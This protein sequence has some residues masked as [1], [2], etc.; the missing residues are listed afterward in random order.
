MQKITDF[1][2]GFCEK[3]CVKTASRCYAP[4]ECEFGWICRLSAVI[5]EK[6]AWGIHMAKQNKK[7]EILE[8]A[9]RIFSRKGSAAKIG[10]IGVEA[11]V[12]DSVI[13][14][15][16]KNK[17]DLM[18]SVLSERLKW[19][20]KRVDEHLKGIIDPASKLSKLIWLQL[21]YHDRHPDY[22]ALQ[23]FECRSNRKF[24]EHEAHRLTMEWAGYFNAPLAEGVSTGQFDPDLDIQVA[25][26]AVLGMLDMENI[27]CLAAGE[28]ENNLSDQEA[29]MDLI[30]A[31]LRAPKK[32][33]QQSCTKSE[34]II[35]AAEKEISQKG[36][37]NAKITHIAAR[38]GVSEGTIYEYFENKDALLFSVMENSIDKHIDVFDEAFSIKEPIRKLRRFIK[39]HFML[40]C[41]RPEF[42][43]IFLTDGLFN[44]N[45]YKSQ[46]YKRFRVYL[47]GLDR[48]MVQ[49]KMAGVIRAQV[50][51][52]LFKNLFLGAFCH[53]TLRWQFAEPEK[54]FNMI[55]EIDS[56]VD[57]IVRSVS[58]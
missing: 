50:S 1:N 25:R 46:A 21:R 42:L 9:E 37:I 26:D 5:S 44:R 2:Y 18:F 4:V 6:G 27:F 11:G 32:A 43:N 36:F 52:R 13:Y 31:L 24:R 17:N 48:I 58:V 55:G 47:E 40:Y 33:V 56:A 15:Y 20:L 51:N 39:L 41:Q 35:R 30:L 29:I 12:T 16:F 57:L 22:A 38:A 10:D 7:A 53:M 8:A 45:F 14:H 28:T 19:E 23:L 34:A 49:G 3:E 54:R